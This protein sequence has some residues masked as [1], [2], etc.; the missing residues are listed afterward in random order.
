MW[1]FISSMLRSGWHDEWSV[2]LV[3]IGELVL[4]VKPMPTRLNPHTFKSESTLRGSAIGVKGRAQPLCYVYMCVVYSLF[5]Y[6]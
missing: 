2:V 1:G 4:S 3:L 5:L 6:F